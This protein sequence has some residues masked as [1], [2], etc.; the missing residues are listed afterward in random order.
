MRKF[1]FSSVLLLASICGHG[2]DP[3]DA[4]FNSPQIHTIKLYFS[5]TGWW[6]S[7][8]AN[9][10]LDQKMLASM[11]FDGVWYDSVG[12]QFKGNSS[13]NNM[14]QK[15]PF[16]I[17]VNEYVSGQD[18]DGLK[19]FNLNNGFK[20][21]TFMREK[22]TLDFCRR[23]GLAAP[24]CTYANLYL[25]DTLWGLYTFIEQVD[26]TFLGTHFSDNDGNLFKGDPQGSLQWFGSMDTNYFHRYE[27]KTNDSLNDWSDLVH[28]L[29]KI[30][31]TLP[32][33]F[34]DS[35]EAALISPSFLNYWAMN[36]LFGNLDSYNGSGH[37]YY[38]YNNPD[39]GRFS[40]IAWDVNEAFGCF[41][42]GMSISQ[43]ENLGINYLPNGRPL[44][45]KMLANVSYFNQYKL[46]LC[47]YIL[48]DFNSA[49]LDPV[50]D[51]LAD[52]LRPSVYADTKKF[53]SSQQ[54][55][56]NR[57]MNTGNTPGLKSFISNRVASVSSQLSSLC[58]T[59]VD[60]NSNSGIMVYPNPAQHKLA[61]GSLQFAITGVAIY[62]TV[63]EILF[64]AEHGNN[65]GLKELELDVTFLP[66]GIYF[67]T[68]LTEEGTFTGKFSVMD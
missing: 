14:S 30:N 59:S 4:I 21:P 58:F 45:Q 55:E 1:F 46:T 29:D 12:A 52:V 17:D 67:Y 43:L 63:G 68:V 16:K 53:F 27:L 33:Y 23:H 44:V 19:K 42:M 32:Q 31:N 2:Q 41:N 35:V 25:N 50:I 56:D 26:K 24:R 61:I 60:D 40:F 6:D 15:K 36:I 20:D 34:F 10:P 11:E 57:T 54:F 64:A 7:L 28:L 22:M 47:D 66:Q 38:V 51:S 5:Q 8:V 13:F 18:V 49:Y 37:N 3:G 65:P 39:A 9:Y 48:Q 62:N